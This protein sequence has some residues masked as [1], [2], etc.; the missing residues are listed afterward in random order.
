MCL[1]RADGSC[2]VRVPRAAARWAFPTAAVALALLCTLAPL[3][4]LVLSLL[5]AL[6][7]TGGAAWA[8][9]AAAPATAPAAAAAP[10][11]AIAPAVTLTVDDGGTAG[12][13]QERDH[14]Q[15][16]LIA[17]APSAAAP[18]MQSGGAAAAMTSSR[19]V[20]VDNLKSAMTAVVVVHH[21]LG[22]FAGSGSLGLSV[23]NFRNALS[24][25]SCGCRFST[26]VRPSIAQYIQPS[27]PR[28][29][30]LLS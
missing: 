30:R 22:A 1:F 13:E 4:Q 12:L 10:A 23:G 14:D 15:A 3:L 16:G 6:A 27:R 8:W 2:R 19:F 24:P 5:L 25:S 11:P 26:S 28:P 7:I 18:P 17:A 21:V 29:G 20:Y 9:L